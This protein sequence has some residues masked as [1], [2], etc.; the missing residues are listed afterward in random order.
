MQANYY[1]TTDGS[2][3]QGPVSLDQLRDLLRQGVVQPGDRV[4]TDGLPDWTPAAD[5]PELRS[6][7]GAVAPAALPADQP[8]AA[9][10]H[11]EVEGPIPERLGSWM[12]FVGIML[13]ILGVLYCASCVG[14]LWGV[15]IIIGGAAL[16][17]A[18]AALEPLTGVPPALAPFLAKLH[19]FFLVTGIVFIIAL[20]ATA[21]VLIF[22]GGILIAI[23]S[24]S[25]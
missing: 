21:L 14:L 1:Y 22:Y 19:T 18:A 2:E 20:V 11:G 13:I 10:L 12:R 17:S 5:R 16:L 24:S 3:R 25:M 23:I 7:P 15:L 8:P 9:T 4:W 6:A